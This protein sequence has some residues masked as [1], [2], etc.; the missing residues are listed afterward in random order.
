MASD[1]D[2][3]LEELHERWRPIE[4]IAAIHRELGLP[5]DEAKAY[6]YDHPAWRDDLAKWDETLDQFEA[7]IVADD[8]EA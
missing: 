5:P 2:R 3:T 6:L 4:A 8:A 7:E 1:L